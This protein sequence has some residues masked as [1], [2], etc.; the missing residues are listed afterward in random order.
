MQECPTD[1]VELI[2]CIAPLREQHGVDASYQQI[3]SAIVSRRVPAFRIGRRW[4]VK[5]ADL[6]AVARAVEYAPKNRRSLATLGVVERR[7][8]TEVS[9]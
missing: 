2:D 8:E 5:V 6:P 9:G 4:W 3:W 1:S 7:R